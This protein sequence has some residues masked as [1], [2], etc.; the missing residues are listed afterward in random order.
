MKRK[1]KTYSLAKTPLNAAQAP[2]ARAKNIHCAR[3]LHAEGGPPEL[4]ELPELPEMP[5]ILSPLLLLWEGG[6]S[7][8]SFLRWRTMLTEEG[9]E[10]GR[11]KCREEKVQKGW[12]VKGVRKGSDVADEG[13][14][15]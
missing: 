15:V 13:G 12:G 8:V 6:G 14:T 2:L 5:G 4:P 9:R 7:G 3:A 11:E 1:E 10:E